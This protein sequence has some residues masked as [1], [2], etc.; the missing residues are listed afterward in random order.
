MK[1]GDELDR[2]PTAGVSRRE[3]LTAGGHRAA[4]LAAGVLLPGAGKRLVDTSTD[5]VTSDDTEEQPDRREG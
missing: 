4:R 5:A 3:F 2:I 1:Y